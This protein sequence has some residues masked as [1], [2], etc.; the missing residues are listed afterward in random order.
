MAINFVFAQRSFS[1]ILIEESVANWKISSKLEKNVG[2]RN[3][4]AVYSVLSFLIR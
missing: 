2:I 4:K 1:L 3:S